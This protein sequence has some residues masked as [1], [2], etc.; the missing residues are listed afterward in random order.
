MATVR[1]LAVALGMKN[2]ESDEIRMT[3][4]ESMTKSE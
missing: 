1:L 3:K 2:A 4:P